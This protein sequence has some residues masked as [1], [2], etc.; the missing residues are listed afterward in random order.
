MRAHAPWVAVGIGM[1]AARCW[2]GGGF[3]DCLFVA[4]AIVMGR[5]LVGFVEAAAETA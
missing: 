5:L 3:V 4:G 2:M 1:I